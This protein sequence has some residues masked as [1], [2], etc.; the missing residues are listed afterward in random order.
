MPRVL[1]EL[2]T[3]YEKSLRI[4]DIYEVRRLLQDKIHQVKKE[5]GLLTLDFS[6]FRLAQ[7]KML[8]VQEVLARRMKDKLGAIR[9]IMSKK[10]E[11]ELCTWL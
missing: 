11:A 8:A 7:C 6:G 5:Q 3:I 10:C 2:E 1:E 4:D 9:N